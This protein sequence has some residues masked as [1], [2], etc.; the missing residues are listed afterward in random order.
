M[1][2]SFLLALF[3]VLGCA[4][5]E[6]ADKLRG[7]K[8]E[9][10]N[11]S[12]KEEAEQMME[13]A[14]EALAE[15]AKQ[16]EAASQIMEAEGA[17]AIFKEVALTD[18]EVLKMGGDVDVIRATVGVDLADDVEELIKAE[19]L[20]EVLEIT[21]EDE[22]GAATVVRGS[23]LL[24]AEVGDEELAAVTRRRLQGSSAVRQEPI[25]HCSFVTFT[26]LPTSMKQPTG[27]WCTKVTSIEMAKIAWLG[28]TIIRMMAEKL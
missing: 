18:E 24:E 21:E 2:R 25:V 26:Q 8:S 28:R 17:G 7:P 14:A 13:M 19:I 10:P 11:V 5:A 27:P 3:V 23:D 20:Q 12:H 15:R 22:G 1:A 4:G 9:I 16:P 6:V